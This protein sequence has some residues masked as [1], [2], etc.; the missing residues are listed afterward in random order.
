MKKIVIIGATSAIAG[1]IARQYAKSGDHLL[2]VGR[3]EERLETL[4]N[5]LKIRGATQVDYLTF[6]ANDFET[7]E[8]L[9][10]N[11]VNKMDEID[12]A[13]IA[14]GTLPDQQAC[15]ADPALT[16]QEL[17]TNGVR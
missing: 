16:L 2:L 10:K 8:G 1:A 15:Q 12:V 5:D 4:A 7:H 9:V 13:L 14:H 17:N 3:S 11:V 6:D